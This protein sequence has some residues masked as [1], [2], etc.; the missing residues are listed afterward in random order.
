[1]MWGVEYLTLGSVGLKMLQEIDS[2]MSLAVAEWGWCVVYGWR[3]F[4][5]LFAS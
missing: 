1:M 2:M 4:V 5:V 3:F